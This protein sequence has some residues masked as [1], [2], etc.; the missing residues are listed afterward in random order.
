MNDTR[1]GGRYLRVPSWAAVRCERAGA[2]SGPR[3]RVHIRL[4]RHRLVFLQ[5]SRDSDNTAEGFV[6]D[7]PGDYAAGEVIDLSITMP[8]GGDTIRLAAEVVEARPEPSG[9]LSRLKAAFLSGDEAATAAL[10]GFL[11]KYYG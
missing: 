1:E 5:P 9:G 4:K 3:E 6:L 8:G 7:V 11:Q 10:T 2:A